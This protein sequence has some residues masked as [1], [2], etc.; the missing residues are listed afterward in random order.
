MNNERVEDLQLDGLKLIQNT[1]GYCFTCDSV[2]L[3]NFIKIKQN[4][5][6]LEI[7]TGSG[8]IS[9]LACHKN[10]AN[11]ITAVEI[12]ESLYSLAERNIKLNNL[13]DKIKVV[14]LDIKDFCKS[15]EY[16]KYD[17]IYTNPPYYDAKSVILSNNKEKDICKY[18]VC[19]NLTELIDSVNKLLKH[20]GRFFIVYPAERLVDLTCELRKKKIEP[21]RLFFTQASPKGNA[22]LVII[23][24]VKGGNPDLKVLPALIL[25]NDNYVQQ[26]KKDYR[27]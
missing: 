13:E 11:D 14:N 15:S 21:K 27:K 19:L 25:N 2:I 5:K 18:E 20:K 17:V 16:Q 9:I 3:A 22:N 24:A 26:I 23:E 8:V 6:A 4:E 10:N 1:E 7:G 12:Q